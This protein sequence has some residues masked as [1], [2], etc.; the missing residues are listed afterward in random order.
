MAECNVIENRIEFWLFDYSQCSEKSTTMKRKVNDNAT[1]S[2]RQCN[3]RIAEL[4]RYS[5]TFHSMT[6]PATSMYMRSESEIYKTF[7]IH[8]LA[9]HMDKWNENPI[10]QFVIVLKSSSFTTQCQMK[11]RSLIDRYSIGKR[12]SVETKE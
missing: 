4:H 1:K 7:E 2:Q 3:V 11:E 12:F 10:G 5:V 8:V 9:N 6:L